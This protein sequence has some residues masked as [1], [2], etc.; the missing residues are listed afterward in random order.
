MERPTQPGDIAREAIRRLASRRQPPTP[1]NF[2]RAYAEVEGREAVVADWPNTLRSLMRQWDSY[3]T[4]L[5]QARKREMLERVIINFGANPDQL[6]IKIANLAKSWGEP[7][8]GVD[9]AEQDSPQPFGSDGEAYTAQQAESRKPAVDLTLPLAE[10]LEQLAAG[11]QDRWPD[12]SDRARDL[13]GHF[14][15]DPTAQ[16]EAITRMTTL[17]REIL[18]RA[19]DDHELLSGFQRLLEALFRNMSSLVV[20]DGWLQGQLH[21]VG[22][23][24]RERLNYHVLHE[25]ERSLQEVIARQSRLRD[26]LQEAKHKLKLLISTF[27]DRVGDL[28]SSTGAYHDRLQDYS[29]RIARAEDIN[30][31]GAVIDSLN[32]DMGSMRE[33]MRRSHVELV[34][35]RSQVEEA[36]RRIQSLERELAEASAMIREDQLTGALNRRGMEEAFARELARA[37]RL[38]SP[39]AVALLDIDH[40]KRLNDSLGHQAGDRAL[41]HLAQVVRQLLR[42]TDSLARY[43][44][45]EFL[46]L[47]PNTGLDEA[48]KVMQR[49]QRELTRQFFMHENQRV[50]ITFSAGV[51]QLAPGED[52]DAV[53]ARADAAMY[54]AKT[55]G[56]NRVE[57]G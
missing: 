24:L 40:F 37:A 13:A 39:L 5:T 33:A 8:G 22:V 20:D 15:G 1:E 23:L 34:Q 3:Q 50:L 49:V 9:V 36:D 57:R 18:V 31:L 10:A 4:G 45:E 38:S 35:A 43:G 14:A 7:T 56:R 30:E 46:I 48:E 28:S 42:P 53:I 44:G 2:S 26:G 32:A 25:A 16:A 54:R 21:T 19:E 17:W 47:L 29:E 52:R 51:V 6:A 41:V 12:L 11:L 55:G 27:I